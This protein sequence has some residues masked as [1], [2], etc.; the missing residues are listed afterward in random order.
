MRMNSMSSSRGLSFTSLFLALFTAAISA[1]GAECGEIYNTGHYGPYDWKDRTNIGHVEVAHFG[2][3][4][5]ALQGDE[6]NLAGNI[7]YLL[8]ASPNHPRALAAVVRFGE[9]F[10]TNKTEHLTYSIECWF[11]RA[12]RFRPKE[13]VSQVLFAQ[14]LA[15]TGR[16]DEAMKQLESATVHANDNGFSHYNIGLMYMSLKEYQH[17]ATSA[18]RARELDFARTDLVNELIR[19]NRWTASESAAAATSSASSGNK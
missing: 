18:R 4:I 13:S 2:P 3:K 14:Y 15:K 16:K 7:S 6:W 10:K 17:A 9:K 12:I 5:E 11:D 19:L 1:H 8:M